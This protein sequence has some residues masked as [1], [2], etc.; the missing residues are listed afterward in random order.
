MRGIL[1]WYIR[2]FSGRDPDKPCVFPFK[3]RGVTY[4][5]CT[6]MGEDKVIKLEKNKNLLLEY[7]DIYRISAPL[8]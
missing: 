6:E 5:R 7:F 8:K 3:W 4:D 2:C 1:I